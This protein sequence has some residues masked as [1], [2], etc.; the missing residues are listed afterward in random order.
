MTIEET[1]ASRAHVHGIVHRLRRHAGTLH[2]P[3]NDDMRTAAD[4]IELFVNQMQIGNCKMDSQHHWRFR[5]GWPM[6]HAVGATAEAAILAVV[7]EVDENRPECQWQGCEA[8]ATTRCSGPLPGETNWAC[9]EH[10]T[11]HGVVPVR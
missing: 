10:K 1:A 5:H 6:T 3:Q 8:K 2:G 7:N 11:G 4:I 9:D